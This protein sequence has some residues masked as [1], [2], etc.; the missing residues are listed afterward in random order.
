MKYQK[1]ELKEK[2]P[3]DAGVIDADRLL[4]VQED[5][6]AEVDGNS[7]ALQDRTFG[8]FAGKSFYLSKQ[9]DWVIGEDD[10]GETVLVP[11]RKE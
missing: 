4:D 9:Y 2:E 7:L 5:V 1:L 8:E 11:L 10:H 6:Y 3:E